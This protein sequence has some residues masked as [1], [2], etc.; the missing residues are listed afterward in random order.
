[1]SET[2]AATPDHVQRVK[3]SVNEFLA[4]GNRSFKELLEFMSS[5]FRMVHEQMFME[6]CQ[7]EFPGKLDY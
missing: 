1:M 3:D 2:F 7:K 6:Y 4:T 5:R